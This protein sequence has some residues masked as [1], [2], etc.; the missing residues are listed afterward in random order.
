MDFY[1][2][3]L[4][5]VGISGIKQI[6]INAEHIPGA[7][8]LIWCCFFFRV[9]ASETYLLN[10][11]IHNKQQVSLFSLNPAGL[12]VKQKQRKIICV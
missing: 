9:C 1:F 8:G 4:N 3:F 11:I 12:I 6:L 2:I 10:W 5:I 7:R